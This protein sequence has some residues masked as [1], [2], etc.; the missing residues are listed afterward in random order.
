[1]DASNLNYVLK[2]EEPVLLAAI[3]GTFITILLIVLD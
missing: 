1:M 2:W 3:L